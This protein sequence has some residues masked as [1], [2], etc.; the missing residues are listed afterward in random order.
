M[1]SEN[2]DRLQY[3]VP[4][5]ETLWTTLLAGVVGVAGSF[6][7]AGPTTDFLAV[8]VTDFV[9]VATPGPIAAEAIQ[10][11]GRASEWLALGSALAISIALVG[12]ASLVGVRIGRRF[13][14]IAGPLLGTYFATWAVAAIV[15][16]APFAA[17]APAVSATIV[18]GLRMRQAPQDDAPPGRRELLKSVAGVLAVS[19]MA[20]VFGLRRTTIETSPLSAI[21]ST[22]RETIRDRLAD[23]ADRSLDVD[24]IPGL[25]SDVGAFYEV[26]INPVNPDVNAVDWTL[27]ITG[28]VDRDVTLD[29]GDLTDLPMEHRFATLRCVGEPLNGRK[30]DNAL[31]TGVPVA[32]LLAEASPRSDCECVMLR[33]ADGYYEEFPLGALEPGLLAF[34]M[35]GRL[36][37]RKHGF[38]VRALVPGHWGEVNVKWLTEI[39]LLERE[40]TGFW[41]LRGWHGTGPVETVAKLHAV[42]RLRDGRMQ[43]GGHAY[44]GTRGIDRVEVSLDGGGTW[45]NARLSSPLPD[46]DVWRQWAF[47]WKPAGDSYE[48]VVRAV[49]GTGTHQPSEE[50]PPY[51]SG[52]TGWVRRTVAP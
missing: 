19:G 48:V 31:W 33:A 14:P 2:G 5:T 41:E 29:Y 43:V 49:D 42:N 18:V 46:E 10:Q 26:D 21:P 44:A 25:V 34:G 24:G 36:L 35:N 30:L 13:D 16:R 11:L 6:A 15:L 27:S 45:A 12:G 32:A 8:P 39:E 38:P 52:P 7:Y 50:S 3:A 22:E 4:D 47:E 23:A 9:I 17:V 28:E 1:A 37:P 40:T 51:P 20:T